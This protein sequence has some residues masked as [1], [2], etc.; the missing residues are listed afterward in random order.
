MIA[1][2]LIIL[3]ICFICY[4]IDNMK[5]KDTNGNN[6]IIV[7]KEDIIKAEQEYMSFA[8]NKFIKYNL[9]P[10]SDSLK[11]LESYNR[12]ADRQIERINEAI[13]KANETKNY[14]EIIDIYNNIFFDE[15]MYFIGDSH[16]MRLAEYYYKSQRYDEAWEFLNN[17]SAYYPKMN[18]Q[19]LKMQIKILKKEKRYISV[20]EKF[21]ILSVYTEESFEKFEN[22][23]NKIIKRIENDSAINADK[24][25]R[26]VKKSKKNYNCES[27]IH[28]ELKKYLN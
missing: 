18:V 5:S 17:L 25:Y 9:P 15:G 11:V 13:Q 3:V 6:K 7:R 10:Q 20:L 21:M 16:I 19:I 1:V 28:E 23:V 8:N 27:I 22:E 14:S 24:L 12:K 2:F 4:K 26:I